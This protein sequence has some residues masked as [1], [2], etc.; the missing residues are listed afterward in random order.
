MSFDPISAAFEVGKTIIERIWPNPEDQARELYKLTELANKG[1]LAELNA[2]VTLLTAQIKVNEVA[3]NHK[4]LFVSGARPAAIWAGVFALVWSG[5]IHPVLIWVWG[6]G[7]AFNYIPVEL[8]VPPLIE[9][10]ALV[11]ILGSLLGVSG[12]RSFDKA[13]GTNKDSL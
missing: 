8:P 11:T 4:S 1:D 3:A 12:M 7:Q 5:I 6:F 10:S 13:K 2:H 9:T